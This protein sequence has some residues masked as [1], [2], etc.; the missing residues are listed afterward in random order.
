MS[1]PPF[2]SS[3]VNWLRAGYP[4]GVPEADYVPLFAILARRLSNDEVA[5]VAHELV[6]SGTLPTDDI[7][8]GVVITRLTDELPR[9]ED[10]Q[11]VR[12]RLVSVGWPVAD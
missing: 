4:N 5:E 8:I 9:E 10:V 3:V 2:L 12:D 6:A 11:R 1:L 7:D